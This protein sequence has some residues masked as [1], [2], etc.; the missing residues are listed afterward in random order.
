V[1]NPGDSVIIDDYDYTTNEEPAILK[2]GNRV[3][4]EFAL[5]GGAQGQVYEYIG[6]EIITNADLDGEDY[7]D[8]S[9]WRRIISRV[10]DT[11][12][13][14]GI[15]N[16]EIDLS[17]EDFT[18]ES[19]WVETS[20]LELG[21]VIPGFSFN[22]SD[23]DSTA[24][25]GLV[26]RNDVRSNVEAYIN[27]VIVS[28]S[29]NI[30]VRAFENAGIWAQDISTVESSGGSM[31]GDGDSIAISAVIATNLVMSN[32]NAYVTDST[33]TTTN[34][35]DVIIYAEN[36]STLIATINSQ[37]EAGGHSVGVVLAF[38]T[39]G[40]DSQNVLFNAIDAIFDTEIGDNNAAEAKAY[41]L[42]T[43]INSS[44]SISVNA[45]TTG[46]F[47][48]LIENAATTIATSIGDSETLSVAP[49]ISMNKLSTNTEA[50]II[51]ANILTA[52]KGDVTVSA[53]D[54]SDMDVTV[55]ASSVALG[56]G[57]KEAKG[58]SIGVSIANNEVKNNVQ[59]YIKHAGSPTQKASV[60]NG[61]L[62]VLSS[63]EATIQADASASAIALAAGA[64]GGTSVAGGG[65]LAFNKILGIDNAY[66][67]NSAFSVNGDVK[68][69]SSNSSIIDANLL[70][71]AI[72]VT[73]SGKKGSA[74]AIGLS[75]ARNII[76]WDSSNQ[77]L[78]ITYTSHDDP[79]TLK[80]GDTVKVV[81]NP[82]MGD[83]YEYIGPD[84]GEDYDINLE[85]Q[86]Y[87]DKSAWQ[88]VN[89][90]GSASEIHA[91]LKGTD[92]SSTGA[93][94]IDAVSESKI[95]ASVLTAA[96]AI[97]ASA[98]GG[99]SVSAAGVY[100]ENKIKTDVKAFID[101]DQ[102]SGI[103]ATRIALLADDGSS[104]QA[105][106][107]AASVAANI[108]GKNSVAVSIGMSL[109]FNEINNQ[110]FAYIANVDH[111]VKTTTG[112]VDISSMSRGRHLFDLD[113]D[114]LGLTFDDLVDATTSDDDIE[115][116][117]NIDEGK[118]D[119]EEDSLILGKLATAFSDRGE[120]I[121]DTEKL[122]SNY[123]YLTTD[124]E[125]TLLFGE[126]VKLDQS[127]QNG[128]VAGK[129]YTFIGNDNTILDLSTID[130]SDTE[131]WELVKPKIRLSKLDDD[132]SWM[133]VTPDG[134]SYTLLKDANGNLSVS[135]LTINAI[136][137][138]A[139]LAAGVGKM[140]I[141]VSGG[142]AVA[143]NNIISNVESYIDSSNIVSAKDVKLD[144]SSAS[145]INAT[146]VAA[147]FSLAAGK[148]GV[149]V[150]IGIAVARNFIG[151]ESDGD[152]D[153]SSVKA[154]VTDS[155]I[156][157]TGKLSQNAIAS[158]DIDALVFSGSAAIAGGGTAGIAVSG[159]GVWA[160]NRI[161][162]D[163]ESSIFGDNTTVINVKDVSL[164]AKD[165]SQISAFA[166]A[167]S[168]AA[169][170]GGTA[171]VS[172]SIGVSLAKNTIDNAVHAF[173]TNANVTSQEDID[174]Y[175]DA[176]GSIDAVSA[177]ASLA[178]GIGGT[179]GIGVSGAG[180][181]AKN[182]ITT[183]TTA[184]AKNSSLNA[185]T[186]VKINAINEAAI[187]AKILAV[188]IA[189]GVG[190]TAG[191]G[192]SIGVAL[193]RNVIGY[194]YANIIY[195]YST[196]DTAPASIETGDRI[197]IEQ[198]VRAGD[199]YEY[200]GKDKLENLLEQE[201]FLL[202]QDYADNSLWKNLS[203]S[204]D[205]APVKAYVQ[206]TSI[207]A[208]DDIIIKAISK[209]TIDAIVI[210]GSAAVSAGGSAGVG[211]SGAGASVN[212]IIA[213]D[214][215]S[216]I[217][218]ASNI[219]ANELTLL[220]DDRS[221]IEAIVGAASVA[222]AFGGSAGVAVSIGVSLAFNQID[223]DT[224]AYIDSVQ[225]MNIGTGGISITATSLSDDLFTFGGISSEDLDD[226]SA[227]ESDD[228]DTL[229]VNEEDEDAAAYTKNLQFLKDKFAEN[230]ITLDD[231]IKLSIISEGI[232]W[233]LVNDS[234]ESY[235]ITTSD[236]GYGVSKTRINTKSV[237]ASVAAGFGGAAGVAV[238][239]AG[240]VAT[241]VILSDTN[242]YLSN[243]NT[244]VEGDIQI[245]A[246]NTSDIAAVVGAISMAVSGGGSAGV[247]VSIGFS[248]AKNYIGYTPDGNAA[249][250]GV[251]AY[252]EDSS[253]S[254]T[255][256][257][258]QT[259]ISGQTINSI[260]FAGS[261]AIAGG[262]AAGVAASGSGVSADNRINIETKASID[263]DGETG[264][265]VQDIQLTASDDSIITAFAGAA[266]IAASV[267]GAA[268]ASVSIGVSIAKNTIE[269]KVYSS[270]LNANNLVKTTSGDITLSATE[271][272]KID[273]ISSAASVAA[274]FGGAA[275]VAVSGAGAEAK[276]IILTKTD[277]YVL[278]SILESASQVDIDAKND[279]R[280]NAFIL[281]AS[282]SAA[283]GGAA[284]VGA[285]IGVA[286][287]RN[288]IGWAP[289]AST[290][291]DYDLTDNPEQLV[292]G[293]LVKI[294]SGVK[295]GDIYEYIGEKT[296]E[297]PE[298]TED[299]TF[300]HQMDFSD[301]KN[302]KLVN[303]S[304]EGATV[305]AYIKD[306]SVNASG[307]LSLDAISTQDINTQV[308]SGSVAIAGGGAAGVALSGAG[309]SVENRIFVNIASFIDGDGES[310]I[311]AD[312][313]NIHA[314]DNSSI[315]ALVGAASIAASF[316]GTAAV[317]FSI[318]VSLAFN[319]V[320][321]TVNAGIE[322][323][324]LVETSSGDINISSQSSG[325][326][327][328]TID[329]SKLVDSQLNDAC[330]TDE[331]NPD[332]GED[333]KSIDETSDEL[334]FDTIKNEFQD[335]GYTIDKNIKLSQIVENELWLLIVEEGGS[336]YIE[337]NT[338]GYTVSKTTINATSVAISL[339]A[340]FG[341]K[342]GVAISGA[343]AQAKNVVL[344]D[345]NAFM[346]NSHVASSGD[347]II[348]ATN[349][350]NIASTVAAISTSQAGGA[351]AGVGAS[352]GSAVAE[353]YIGYSTAGEKQSKGVRSY[354]VNTS[355]DADGNL[356]Q[357]TYS[358]QKISASVLSASMAIAGSGIA[359]VGT[360]GS[361]VKAENKI[362]IDI[363]TFIDGDGTQGIKAASISLDANDHSEI[364]ARAG[365][366][367]LAGSFG[368]TGASV[369]IGVSLAR[370]IIDNFVKA[371]IDNADQGVESTTGDITINAL[372]DATINVISSAAS[373]A[374]AY[375]MTGVSVSGA[376]AE[377]TNI[378]YSGAD[379]HI[380]GSE[381][382]SAQ[383]LILDSKNTSSIEAFILTASFALSSGGAAFGASIGVSLARNFIGSNPYGGI[384]DY[385]TLT[386]DP[387]SIQKGQKVKIDESSGVRGGDVYEY[388]GDETLFRESGNDVEDNLLFQAD[389]SDRLK[390]KQLLQESDAPVTTYIENSG[391]QTTR[392]LRQRAHSEQEIDSE[393][394][395]GSV[396]ASMGA[397]SASISGAGSSTTNTISSTVKSYISDTTETGIQAGSDIQLEAKDT[398]KIQADTE[399]A[400]IA[401]AY[402]MYG[403]LAAA[404]GVSLAENS[405]DNVVESYV[406]ASTV[407]TTEGSL[408]IN[409]MEHATINSD[410]QATAVAAGTSLSVSG[411]GASTNILVDTETRAY[412]S[413]STL[414]IA[415]DLTI[416]SEATS[417]GRA[418]IGSTAVSIG[419][420]AA[421]AS[422]TVA[423][424]V[425]T[426]TVEA[427]IESST[428]TAET[429]KINAKA[430][431]P[432]VYAETIGLSVS[433][434][435]AIGASVATIDVKGDIKAG[436]GDNVTLSGR[437][438]AIVSESNDDILAKSVAGSG[439]LLL[440]VAGA[441][442]EVTSDSDIVA[443]IGD[444]SNIVVNTLD[445][446]ANH[447]ETSDGKADAASIGLAAGTGAGIINTFL[448]EVK[449]DIGS[450]AFVAA[451]TILISAS[452]KLTKEKYA[453]DH[454]LRSGSAGGVNVSVLLS[455]TQ[456]GTD[457]NK[458]KALVNIGKGSQLIVNNGE[459]GIFDVSAEADVYG[460]DN[461]KVEGVAGFGIS[462]AKSEIK[463]NTLANVNLDEATLKNIGGDIYLT[464]RTTSETNTSASLFSAA[465]ISGYGG[466]EANGLVDAEN[467]ISL[468]DAT[469]TAKDVYLFA[470]K[471]RY[472]IIN[473]LDGY[474][475]AQVTMASTLPNISDPDPEMTIKE[476]NLITITGQSN[477]QAFQDVNLTSREGIG[478]DERGTTYGRSTSVSGVPY[479][480]EA[481]DNSTVES[482]NLVTISPEAKLEAALTNKTYIRIL[483]MS[484]GGESQLDPE[485][486]GTE[487][488]EQ[489]KLD[490]NLNIHMKYEY[491]PL[492]VNTAT[493][494]TTDQET[495]STIT[496]ENLQYL[497]DIL[498]DK[499]Y[500]I[501][502][503][504]LNTPQLNYESLSNLLIEQK[505]NLEDWM[506]N[507]SG[508]PE[509]LA[510]YQTQLDALLKDMEAL[511][512][513]ETITNEEGNEVIVTKDG[514]DVI[515]LDLP[516][517]M[518]SPGSIYIDA[519]DTS[520][521]SIQPLVGSSLIA[522]ADAR[523]DI[524]NK[525]PFGL[526]V[527][528]T[529][530]SD[531]RTMLVVD[532]NL[533]TFKPGNVYVNNSSLSGDD[534]NAETSEIKIVQDSFSASQYGIDDLTM[535]NI[536]QDIY[537]VGEINNE[538]GAVTIINIEGS[539]KVSGNINAGELDIQAVGNFDLN[540]EDWYHVRDPRQFIE[541]PNSQVFN[542]DGFS[543]QKSWE[544]YSDLSDAIFEGGY[545][546]K[547]R[548]VAQKRVT[549]TAKYLDINGLIQSGLDTVTLT[550]DE[551]FDADSTI[552]F[553][554][555]EG[556][557]IDGISFGEDGQKI[558]G[559]FDAANKSIVIEEFAPQ[560]GDITLT[561][562]IISTGNGCLRVADGD[563]NITINN[564]SNYDLVI[565]G[566]DMSHEMP[567][568]IT[569][570]D[571]LTLK[572]VV[573]AVK[574]DQ[575]EET[576]YQGALEDNGIVYSQEG[577]AS[578][579]SF[580]EEIIYQPVEGRYYMWVEGQEA[581]K[582][583]VSKY[584]KK[585]FNL[586]GVSWDFLAADDSYEWKNTEFKDAEPLLESEIIAYVNGEDSEKLPDYA[587]DM[588]YT[589]KY[590][591][592]ED[593]R[594]E[595]I[596]DVT[597]VRHNFAMIY[598]YIGENGVKLEL[599][600]ADYTDTE[601]WEFI[602]PND[603]IWQPNP[604]QNRFDSTYKGKA[605]YIKSWE[606]GG[607][608]LQE[609]T[610]HT[611]LTT[612]TGVKDYYTHTLKADYP[613]K[614]EFV[615]QEDPGVTINSKG[616]VSLTGNIIEP[617]DANSIEL[618][619]EGSITASDGV[620]LF[621]HIEDMVVNGDLKLSIESQ[622]Q[623]ANITA[624]GDIDLTIFSTD[625]TN[626]IIS[627]GNITST[628]GNVAI[629]AGHGI[630]MASIDSIIC[631]N[632]IELK[633]N[634]GNI[635][636]IV[637][638]SFTGFGG[639]AALALGD[640]SI[641]EKEGNLLLIDP[642]SWDASIEST[643]GNIIIETT[644][645]DIQ[646]GFF[647]NQMSKSEIN[648]DLME[649]IANSGYTE[650]AIKYAV[651]SNLIKEIYPHAIAFPNAN[652]TELLNIS[653]SNITLITKGETS[654]IGTVTDRLSINNPQDFENL[655]L[656]EKQ[657]LASAGPGDV[658]GIT[659]ELY[660][661]SGEN[662][663]VDLTHV[664]LVT[665]TTLV[666]DLISNKVY[667][668]T[669]ANG[670][671]VDLYN[672]DYA[673]DPNWEVSDI[674]PQDFVEHTGQHKY[675][676]NY[677]N[678]AQF[679]ND[680]LWQKINIDYMTHL[681]LSEPQTISIESD[682]N[683]LVQ[684]NENIYGLY[685]YQGDAQS[686]DLSEQDYTD[687]TLWKKVT[688]DAATNDG[689]IDLKTG[690]IV[691]NKF[692]IEN[693]M[694]QVFD[695]VN[696]SSSGVLSANANSIAIGAKGDLTIDSINVEK[697][698]RITSDSSI[699][700]SETTEIMTQ[701]QGADIYVQAGSSIHVREGAK[702][703]AGLEFGEDGFSIIG[704]SS[705]IQLIAGGELVIEGNI[706]ASQDITLIAGTSDDIIQIQDQVNSIPGKITYQREASSEIVNEL[707]NGQLSDSLK[708]EFIDSG[709]ELQGNIT[710]KVI[711]SENTYEISDQAGHTY[712]LK[713]QYSEHTG[714]LE[715]LD[716][717]LPTP[718]YNT[719][720]FSMFINGNI[721]NV[722]NHATLTIES[723]HDIIL[724]GNIDRQG[725]NVDISITTL[726]E[727]FFFSEIETKIGG[728]TEDLYDQIIISGSATL[729]N[730]TIKTKVYE[731]YIPNISDT[732]DF[733]KFDTLTG[734]FEKASGIYG[735]GEGD[736]FLE[737]EQS[738]NSIQL[739]TTGFGNGDF[740]P[741]LPP[742][743]L[744]MFGMFISDYFPGDTLDLAGDFVIGKSVGVSGGMHLEKESPNLITLSITDNT[745]M[746]TSGENGL[747]VS[748][749]TG[750]AIITDT[751]VAAQMIGDGNLVG[752]DDFNL[753]GTDME[754]KL[755]ST[756]AAIDKLIDYNGQQT[757]VQYDDEIELLQVT[758]DMEGDIIGFIT[759]SGHF[760]FQKREHA[761]DAPVLAVSD[762]VR[763]GLEAGPFFVGVDGGKLGLGLH[764]DDTFVVY[765]QGNLRLD[766][767]DF[768][769]ES[770][771]RVTIQYNTSDDDYFRTI[772]IG[773]I[774]IEMDV[775]ANGVA[776]SAE[777]VN[778]NIADFLI[779]QGDFGFR[780]S[781]E[782][783]EAVARDVTAVAQAG[784]FRVGVV[785]ANLGMYLNED[786]TKAFEV[787]GS[788]IL[789]L[790]LDIDV[791]SFESI[792]V[793]MNDSG[794]GYTGET[795]KIAEVS[796]TF[797]YLPAS[798][799]LFELEVKNIELNLFDAF[800]LKGNIGFQQSSQSVVLA[801]STVVEIDY[802]GFGG[803]ELE[804]FIGF[805]RGKDDA[806]GLTLQDVTFG[807]AIFTPKD[808][809]TEFVGINWTA[810]TAQAGLIAPVGL[811][812]ELVISTNNLKVEI[813]QV[814]GEGAE[815]FQVIDFAHEDVTISIPTGGER[816]LLTMDGS[817]GNLIRA[818]GEI[819]ITVSEF[820]HVS[821]GIGFEISTQ[822]V[823]LS[824]GSSVLA[825]TLLFGASNLNA[826][827]GVNGPYDQPG[828]MGFAL[829]D[830]DFG[831]ALMTPADEM[832]SR[833]WLSLKASVGSATFLGIPGLSILG[834]L[835][836]DFNVAINTG[837]GED[838]LTVMHLADNPISVPTGG[839]AIILDFDGSDKELL[840]ISGHIGLNILDFFYVDGYIAFEKSSELL[841]L[842]DGTQ[843][844]TNVLT[845]GA[846]DLDAFV[847]VGGPGDK[848]GA[849][850][851]SLV[852]VNLALAMLKPSDEQDA[853]SWLAMKVEVDSASFVG[854][855]GLTLGVED[856]KVEINSSNETD[857][858][859]DFSD[860]PLEVITGN[861]NSVF[862]DF[863]GDDGQMV[864]AE[865]NLAINI[866]GF[867]YVS[868]TIAIE[869]QK[870]TFNLNDGSSI[871]TQ[872]LT[873]GASND[874]D[875]FVGIGGP[876]DQPGA[877]G[878][879]ITDVN[880]ALALIKPIDT[881]DDRSWTALK[882]DV[883]NAS[884]IGVD[885]LTLSVSSVIVEI[886]QGS[887]EN[888]V[889][890]FATTPFDVNTGAGN[891]VYFD[892]DGEKGPSIKAEGDV[893]INIFNFFYVKG[894]I[895]FETYTETITLSDGST[896]EA[897]MMTIG[898]SND[899]DAFVGV[900]GPG[901]QPGAL[902]LSLSDVNF[903]LGI[904]KP[905][906]NTDNRSWVSLKA[907]VGEAAFIG[908]DA[909]TLSI[910]QL[911]VEINQGTGDGNDTVVHYADNPL[912]VN[913]GGGNSVSFDF[914]GA[915]GQFIKAEGLVE[916]NLFD[917]F[918]VKG[919]IAFENRTE[920]ITLSD[921]STIDV[922]VMTIGASEDLD[923]FVGINGP[924]DN[925]GALV[926]CP[927][928]SE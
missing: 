291:Y 189:A 247:G 534:T 810:V 831:L 60:L 500:V 737:L 602:R 772:N 285:S 561:G 437:S 411:G 399:A 599:S 121:A 549:I 69:S 586:V 61:N 207:N 103:S 887:E 636:V 135:K 805:N 764:A 668:Y 176:I 239:G 37:V 916:I 50:S 258:I 328:F 448:T 380:K 690:D 53:K 509:A 270:I 523:I 806:V 347:V 607:G 694:I 209:Q 799:D 325:K 100:A 807:A 324:D 132:N 902:G 572:K 808:E 315:E 617:E 436:L 793:R 492:K 698:L 401:A 766:V 564:E 909:I 662:R 533:T 600:E 693:L 97:S 430:K 42:N 371:Y 66:I 326:K 585:S 359:G 878:L 559:F 72:A 187:N 601:T 927:K 919:A 501:K 629:N 667:K 455:E 769:Q 242:A 63:K 223:T 384:Y 145:N 64:K 638:S 573:Y 552:S 556:N 45:K 46:I 474:S 673:N 707:E 48:A 756:G 480:D 587:E 309:A 795:L 853:R 683:V 275:G 678:E 151:F 153:R 364:T 156:T 38:N 490:L 157:A 373:L 197:K 560:A 205:R 499:F 658:T 893:E 43:S 368:G 811:P 720:D 471:D 111:G 86:N 785:D 786:G 750:G 848:P 542:Q 891:S 405:I 431:Q 376:G 192:A 278:N 581:T 15:D 39:I 310:G 78:D 598:R 537:V 444:N 241:N 583:E 696:L 755:N 16:E 553:T 651:S 539:V 233:L 881:Q 718:L 872:I 591:Q 4:L 253:I 760:G 317:S 528:D 697:N 675:V 517:I 105:I 265:S 778:I 234:G 525:S 515:F 563:P 238:S 616:S 911:A 729:F 752:V 926:S 536:D 98:K 568:Q 757:Q 797:D 840:Q 915:K 82:L 419:A 104:I 900:G 273:A 375:G 79:V 844:E 514:L 576:H 396:A 746:M 529:K 339:S 302:W 822:D 41:T 627:V 284:G 489:E 623:P 814:S 603:G 89:L 745:G 505:N 274:S 394:I 329:E 115:S 92:L 211:V 454:N 767:E 355:I 682:N 794:V 706:A 723:N 677:N 90:K 179:A 348:N 784:E 484:L 923:A 712:L 337:K 702:M 748:S 343:G 565:E 832:D 206:N 883:G 901:D 55:A 219:T 554:D 367:S 608:W 922:N 640:I 392:H 245:V 467:L 208:G 168:V 889:I 734:E 710:V 14:V 299:E 277:A 709:I 162:V 144:A 672:Q 250:A 114:Q 286:L 185:T 476:K 905:D 221:S 260:V 246:T 3:R 809:E 569:I 27:K 524:V 158:Q 486:L 403:G 727:V 51:N 29:G 669:G 314:N 230:G 54:T 780:K 604:S 181:E 622:D 215:A 240:A 340:G 545:T 330:F 345:T 35:G 521:S 876:G 26:V 540:V 155:S 210:S 481:S 295:Q 318:G 612:M 150:S 136:S 511:G 874:L 116:T 906:D 107:G 695:D 494:D 535:P 771:T 818:Q 282:L 487:L 686:I 789:E 504:E 70:T 298:N 31:F 628:S 674:K 510:R 67:E 167:A 77:N 28:A 863:D 507:H 681:I 432:D 851:L 283:G 453:L 244:S 227:Q 261:A 578:N 928:S 268:G 342:A 9:K 777:D 741:Q 442:S 427:Y 451:N 131:N 217:Q 378:I 141:A 269:N 353:N 251:R 143:V 404:V 749:L 904:M 773:D 684:Y 828:A 259:A 753:T 642:P 180:A 551:N 236:E 547:S 530:I 130:Y 249:S 894:T 172:V 689:T 323:A 171:G 281:A 184:Y 699:I 516:D 11:Y 73:I 824:D 129:I 526:R 730:T 128:G 506:I 867:F 414:N 56:V 713:L 550:I 711:L 482:T 428:V 393:V 613:I 252:V 222:A 918:I 266:S 877:I 843:V 5:G 224:N 774:T 95:D 845:V 722:G 685:Q 700:L 584:E 32:A 676:S 783:I 123:T 174:I 409:A 377:A 365:A 118:I 731:D 429:I 912:L 580:G 369:S 190:G 479:G 896:I 449:V 292:T 271:N 421:A 59:A 360:S 870:E 149:G 781:G 898:A 262:G 611:K 439:A 465:A 457:T 23:S 827:V 8:S 81:K 313:I 212:N 366:A 661:Y 68:I 10:G 776:V 708:N 461:V 819:T 619:T 621:G 837:T 740:M 666:N 440:A 519:N 311:I 417:S 735:F 402:G 880:F 177:A 464:A 850:G 256:H 435:L 463:A 333:E 71:K 858:V 645:G 846:S 543:Q 716:I 637:D 625:N 527:Y 520:Q 21:E 166:G 49:I 468:N 714:Q 341:G 96:A 363:E 452:N 512:L 647:E 498:D 372:E 125:N 839:E 381:I 164:I 152:E 800:Y 656:E 680:T 17:T 920:N 334:I 762:N 44:G 574:D 779:I 715:S 803:S 624:T 742:S 304:K 99:N 657:A 62:T 80:A 646:D 400:S 503:V 860:T 186:D 493:I 620:G 483:P 140:G 306:S 571:S 472:G 183:G 88:Q 826:F 191:V 588:V 120:T 618:N 422:G 679:M 888:S 297:R 312:R 338:D 122:S 728:I 660:I 148:N 146:V 632:R 293:D 532:G 264:I 866:F 705:D 485:R 639:V 548:I 398:S 562:Q 747:R 864:K 423:N 101:G 847:G 531:A 30:S 385:N 890:D 235:T 175:S 594:I 276:N 913:T 255:G 871:E 163:V 854:V 126:T 590:E 775:Y 287:A 445:V 267:G 407:E 374:A 124:G 538:D 410:A 605:S 322:N 825:N 582:V 106:A 216:F 557:T 76:G 770:E 19:N 459:K 102:S 280:I 724:A 218:T 652:S 921:E 226:A 446:R 412:A 692:Y 665:D 358:E 653:G 739:K 357:T 379:A 856:L 199:V 308:F 13:Y 852:D 350:S 290:D 195:D 857:A 761:W 687:E 228:E 40:W 924:G 641:V 834:D 296:I 610:Y 596:Q 835:L 577:N 52:Q 555:D 194:G 579:H 443:M 488:T 654:Q 614:V 193:A 497:A 25:G 91:Y 758:G 65:T 165:S 303:I 138:A 817:K 305:Q 875:A 301:I 188:S 47:N 1:L 335:N 855:E 361:G 58:V 389:Y 609:K 907:D 743:E 346:K 225:T 173:I 34:N 294:T 349:T 820:F 841:T 631:G 664:E 812:D 732:F 354:V 634:E 202:T 829:L 232:S 415:D 496:Q 237:A 154:Y 788:P 798:F 650:D 133:L 859:A 213:V 466:A 765:A 733:L 895:A 546:S 279:S 473:L 738:D 134:T 196:D 544:E 424:I 182:I 83:V 513:T 522:R 408:S 849:I 790:G 763:A 383:D 792:T 198:G 670:L 139:S 447:T 220:A 589:I 416:T 214:I 914:D 24:F 456:I 332:T 518:A 865:G 801:D 413:G 263:G 257:L 862:L 659:Y 395:T 254:A 744:D 387:A 170:L 229:L 882:A 899:L 725:L 426:P 6:D 18:N 370:N 462:H 663:T 719:H 925:P 22:V 821:G 112:D 649:D 391:V 418:I 606:T 441:Q 736:R 754:F 886:N 615:Q 478:G 823:Q 593:L 655:T 20:Q 879:S 93:L 897:D 231:D 717:L 830:V 110:V 388:I 57:T 595:L 691:A 352:V 575:I 289:Y 592:K 633:A 321:N 137:A 113:M 838:N 816:M 159:S 644:N 7:T 759:I 804:A 861:D 2:K 450:Q 635:D 475:D 169:S 566:I 33:L 127:Y 178:A 802:I 597:E 434:G 884:F 751:G 701:G 160:E 502:P 336:Y 787:S 390:W 782:N 319:E 721:T 626:K 873:I 307:D 108:S 327:L 903:A 75:V 142:A 382:I 813:N 397:Y 316:G 688:S 351:F 204:E 458:F 386:S 842:S 438:L 300:F 203:L 36:A 200:I 470:G 433:T 406:K 87:G 147:S 94:T 917:F 815:N 791:F 344:N 570:I 768:H 248:L 425:I 910:S 833:S 671:L 630:S 885:N 495:G 704:E 541:Y 74:Y 272:A 648:K 12:K 869:T 567:G 119:Q 420:I 84:L 109:A 460:V 908:F 362:G 703:F 836:K 320:Q 331:D 868:G 161:A 117:F 288:F 356:S 85:T 558:D 726:S 201:N 796:Y 892:F 469:V 243:S 477:I 643:S 508:N 491:A